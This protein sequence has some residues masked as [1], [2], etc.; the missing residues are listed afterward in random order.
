M[1]IKFTKETFHETIEEAKPLLIQHWEELARNKELFPLDP[2]YE[3]YFSLE[4][5]GKLRIYTVRRNGE[6]IGYACYMV[7]KNLHYRTM[8]CAVSDIFWLHPSVR[9]GSLGI[10]LFKFIESELSSEKVNLMH[11]TYKIEHPAA[12]SV[13]KYLGHTSIETGCA[14]VLTKEVI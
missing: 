7:S 4:K 1:E 14:K 11:T 10:K 6:L 8:T 5:L 12:G 9:R 2:D 13:L 3:S